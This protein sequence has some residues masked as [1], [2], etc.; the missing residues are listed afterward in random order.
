MT[1]GGL[2]RAPIPKDVQNVLDVG[3]GTGIWAIDFADQY[4]SA[5]VIGTDLSPVQPSYVPPNCRFYVEN[6]EE[7]WGFETQFDYIHSRM[8]FIGI[9]DWPQFFKQAFAA[10]KPGGW[11]EMQDL[12]F[13]ARADDGTAGPDSPMVEW[14]R[15][16]IE[17]AKN[18]GVDLAASEQ[19]HHMLAGAGFVDINVETFGWPVN[20]W[21]KDPAM[22]RMGVYNNAN[23]LQG[24]HGFTMAFFARGLHWN[25]KDIAEY[26]EKV[27]AHANDL[28]SH[29]YI[30]VVFFWA[31]KPAAP[32][33]QEA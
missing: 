33:G 17:G 10:L 28:R 31:R 23:F 5:M 13:P 12:T 21:P 20:R 7:P 26:V 24:V 1:L 11:L 2:H 4:P 27:K 14:S 6:A 25:P 22:K 3:T 30:P 19:F 32:E 8:L 16:M 15:L 18:V 9:R 29:V